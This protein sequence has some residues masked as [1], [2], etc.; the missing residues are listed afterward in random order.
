MMLASAALLALLLLD[1]SAGDETCIINMKWNSTRNLPICHCNNAFITDAMRSCK[2][3]ALSPS[4]QMCHSRDLALEGNARREFSL[5]QGGFRM[6]RVKSF[7]SLLGPGTD[8]KKAGNEEAENSANI[9][10]AGEKAEYMEVRLPVPVPAPVPVQKKVDKKEFEKNADKDKSEELEKNADNQK[11]KDIPSKSGEIVG[12]FSFKEMMDM[13]PSS[14]SLHKSGLLRVAISALWI[15]LGIAFYLQPGTFSSQVVLAFIAPLLICA[16]P[17]SYLIGGHV[18]YGNWNMFHLY[19]STN[20]PVAAG[21]LCW[22]LG[23]IF[24]AMFAF[25]G[26]GQLLKQFQD[27]KAALPILA[28]IRVLLPAMIFIGNKHE[29]HVMIEAGFGSFPVF[30]IIQCIAC[31]LLCVGV[32]APG[33]CLILVVCTTMS[34]GECFHHHFKCRTLLLGIL[35]FTPC[36]ERFSLMAFAP[37]VRVPKIQWHPGTVWPNAT[38]LFRIHMGMVYFASGVDK[39]RTSWIQGYTLQKAFLHYGNARHFRSFFVWAIPHTEEQLTICAMMTWP[40]IMAE[41]CLPFLFWTRFQMH[42]VVVGFILHLGMS[43]TL[44]GLCGFTQIAWLGL[45]GCLDSEWVA[46]KLQKDSGVAKAV[47]GVF[48]AMMLVELL[49]L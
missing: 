19:S 29:V 18:F 11:S 34:M 4:F 12:W 16:P 1:F 15:G 21:L 25:S 7:T 46:D 33:A 30:G 40:V 31:L 47:F 49:R 22:L 9:S 26:S 41:L 39:L 6:H 3:R 17:M 8:K 42:A 14:L 13:K 38:A 32:Y 28:I 45:L 48:V 43:L 10:K 2:G 44:G 5:I 27:Q 24:L 20:S 36:S 23:L 35:A 37:S